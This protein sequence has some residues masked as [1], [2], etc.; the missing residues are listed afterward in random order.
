ME[1]KVC[2]GCKRLFQYIT[3]PEL[4]PKC[5]Q[6]EEEY[7][8]K[9]KAYLKKNPGATLM[10]VSKETGVSTV[11]I[12]SFLRSGRLEVAPESPIHMGCERCGCQIR[13]GRYCTNCTN[14]LTSELKE[15]GKILT[16]QSTKKEV[17]EGRMRYFKANE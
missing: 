12:E 4:C 11:L 5:K 2:K 1:V 14:E 13:T 17:L 9:V 10:T 7:F 3:G 6:T 8:Q 15:A 16:K